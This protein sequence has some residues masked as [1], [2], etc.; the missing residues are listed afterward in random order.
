MLFETLIEQL[1]SDQ[2]YPH[3]V[4][5]PIQVIQTHD[6]AVF[7]TG[8]YAYKLKKPV[9]F[10]FLDYST[11]AKRKYYLEQELELNLK[12][13]PDIYLEVLSINLQANQLKIKGE[14]DII[15][16]ILK[17]HQFPQD[18]LLINL[19]EA[20]KLKEIH[21]QELA[22]IVAD[23]HLH[24]QTNDYITSFGDPVNIKKYLDQNFEQTQKYIGSLQTQQQYDQ[25]VVF[26]E[27]FFQN[28]SDILKNRQTQNKIRECHGDL[29][30]KNICF[31]N[32]KIRLFDRIEFNDNFRYV[33]TMY[34]VAFTIMDLDSRG[35]CDL[36][37]IFLN[38]YL[39]Q[40][41]DWAGLEV[42]P[43]Y[44]SRQAYVRAKINS[45]MLEDP[46]I[47]TPEKQTSSKSA[48]DYYRLA[49]QYCLRKT[50]KLILMSGPSG[51]GKSTVAHYLAQKLNAI[52][53]RSDAVRKNLARIALQE[54]ATEDLYS[55]QM[56]HLTYQRLLE[57]G[58]LALESGF[59]VI[60]DAKFDRK[61]WRDLANSELMIYCYAPLDIL[62]ERL[63]KRKNDISDA[64]KD[65]LE[66]QLSSA[67]PFTLSEK[68]HLLVLDTTAN[69]QKQLNKILE[70]KYYEK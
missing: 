27:E 70:E 55:S 54:K 57:L 62:K 59:S 23:F 41:G 53:I 24:S 42:L 69:W 68:N 10:G 30:L 7:L 3:P 49:Y 38:S 22:K 61:Y 45:L 12:I 2:A 4:Q 5:L 36:S 44:L 15:E 19:F 28:K 21:L 52:H 32:N 34:D 16:Y 9:N 11:L 48:A 40:T 47:P 35:R 37:N 18:C 14:G 63:D 25:T 31:W 39:E 58:R 8:D 20:G 1:Q 51:S 67:E 64:T 46:Q 33:D 29:H 66:L 43:M 13:A 50:A 60:L 56:N 6:A 17:M 65:L 26:S